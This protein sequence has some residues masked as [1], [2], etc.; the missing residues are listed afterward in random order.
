MKNKLIVWALLVL[1]VGCKVTKDNRAYTR[2]IGDTQ[3]ADRTY[4]T[5]AVSHP[6][7]NVIYYGKDSII[8][9][10]VIDNSKLNNA[11]SI[12]DSLLDKLLNPSDTLVID[13]DS[14]RDAIKTQIGKT[15]VT[16]IVTV[17][18]TRIDTIIDIRQVKDL[19]VQI[20]TVQG[21]NTELNNQVTKLKASNTHKIII[22]SIL[23]LLILLFV[24][25][26]I[27]KK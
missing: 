16:K 17:N 23:I 15:T 8:T 6:C 14:L 27:K 21:Q 5:L 11:N 7:T 3:L 24:Y 1:L 13:I 25:L 19:T 20:A 9:D 22:M 12:I 4:K 10:T 26:L 18:K 2:V